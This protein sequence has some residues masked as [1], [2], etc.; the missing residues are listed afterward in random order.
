MLYNF[1]STKESKTNKKIDKL[2][3]NKTEIKIMKKK[4]NG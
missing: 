3:Q 2:K 4:Y 1:I